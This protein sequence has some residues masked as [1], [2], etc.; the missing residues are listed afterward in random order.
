MSLPAGSKAPK[1][2]RFTIKT[3]SVDGTL[4]ASV[5]VRVLNPKTGVQSTWGPMTP[6]SSTTTAVVC[7]YVLASDGSSVPDQGPYACVAW[8]Y[9]SG[10]AL[11]D[12][13]QANNLR[14]GAALPVTEM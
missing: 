12:V 8:L 3:G 5:R 2:V 11:L 10:G 13:T 6:V 7:T 14:V 1:M 4:V 9:A